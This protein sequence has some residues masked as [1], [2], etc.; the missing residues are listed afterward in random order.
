M[1]RLDGVFWFDDNYKIRLIS[2][3]ENDFELNDDNIKSLVKD[4]KIPFNVTYRPYGIVLFNHKTLCY[5]I[6][7]STKG[8][9]ISGLLKENID[10]IKGAFNM[11]NTRVDLRLEESLW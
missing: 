2:V 9:L 4:C 5:E 10:L 7:L 11:G 1:Y 6:V 8:L 3:N